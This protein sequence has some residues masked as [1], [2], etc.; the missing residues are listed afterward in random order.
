MWFAIYGAAPRALSVKHETVANHFAQKVSD[1][2]Q[3]LRDLQHQAIDEHHDDSHGDDHHNEEGEH[4]EEPSE[5][6]NPEHA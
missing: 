6:H 2:L 1:E 4:H 3:K 5:E